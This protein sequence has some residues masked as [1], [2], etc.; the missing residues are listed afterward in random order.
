[1]HEVW[2]TVTVIMPVRNE[3]AF[4][5]RSLGAVLEQD[6]PPEKVEIIVADGMSDD[7]TLSII[8]SLPGVDRVTIIENPE[9]IQSYGLNH[10]LEHARGDYIIRVDGHTII[11][12]D[13]IKQCVT[14]LQQTGAANVGGA[15]NPVGITAF[16]KA[17]AA[18]GKSPFAVPTT[19]HH[20]ETACYTDTVY[21]GA[22]PRTVFEQIGGFNP[23]LVTNQDYELNYRIRANGGAIYFNPAIQSQYYSRQTL[24]SL[25]RQYYRYGRGKVK[26][27]RLHPASLRPRQVVA[28]LFVA[29]LV[30]GPVLA[31]LWRPFGILW[32]AGI[33]AYLILSVIFAVRA[34]Q[35]AA[36]TP[37]IWRVMLVFFIMHLAWG[38]GFWRELLKPGPL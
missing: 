7:D 16:G 15:M 18:A 1:M 5:A 24:R 13:Y 38:V 30:S 10:A 11:A 25:M 27:L 3:A 35:R 36:D 9:R 32:L 12:P 29:G 37:P 28:P 21:M 8:Q 31:I 14:T 22:W 19:F 2:P 20:S 6:Y 34:A 4:I 23:Q 17:I 33:T 26:T